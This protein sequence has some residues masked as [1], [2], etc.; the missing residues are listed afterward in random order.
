[1]ARENGPIP[2]MDTNSAK[3]YA[4]PKALLSWPGAWILFCVLCNV[5]GWT[6]SALNALRPAGYVVAFGIGLALLTIWQQRTGSPLFPRL[7]L[8]TL[9]AGF[10]K[11]LKTAFLAL[12][13]LTILGGILY[14]P[15][16]YDGLAYRVPR[17]L[18]WISEGRWHWIPTIFNRLN[19]RSCGIEWVS[20]PLVLFTHTDR[21]L[22]LINVI[23][24][25]LLP[26]LVYSTFV[27]LGVKQRVAWF[28]MWLVPTGYCYLLQAG[29]IGNDLFGSVFPLAALHFALRA[30]RRQSFVDAGLA[31]LAA[32]LATSSKAS[33]LPLV[34]PV[35]V[36]LVPCRGLLQ[37]KFVWLPLLACLSL[38]ASMVPTAWL[39]LRHC[40][41]WSGARAED[42]GG[43]NGNPLIRLP[44]NILVLGLQN[45]APPIFPFAGPWNLIA[46]RMIPSRFKE[47]LSRNY[48]EPGGYNYA[49]TELQWE[50]NAGFGCGLS[51]LLLAGGL[52]GCRSAK[53]RDEHRIKLMSPPH[54]SGLR[55]RSASNNL[56]WLAIAIACL[57]YLSAWC[58]SQVGRLAAPYYPFLAGGVLLLPGHSRVI[59]LACWKWLV[60][61]T[62]TL[63]LL[64]LVI[65][66]TRPLWPAITILSKLDKGE[67][68]VKLARETY[69]VNR[70]RP[71]ALAPLLLQIP[72]NQPVI[73]LLAFDEIETSLW[74]PFGHQR[75][76]HVTPW[77]TAVSLR[78]QGISQILIK[79]HSFEG[80]FHLPFSQ[81][82]SNVDG[83]LIKTMPLVS[84]G[85]IGIE[86]WQ[87]VQLNPLSSKLKQFK[88]ELNRVYSPAND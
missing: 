58:L 73:G 78:N 7:R 66:P 59:R 77:D 86:Y 80:Y 64:A 68:L 12:T 84:K 44:N 20:A 4:E 39:N 75:I 27:Q 61:A 21:W 47:V 26:G 10:C 15:S 63:S 13:C 70:Q 23:S 18:H 11:P 6:L 22:F 46:A 25:L 28:W 82:L 52:A 50:V 33:N 54:P 85:A 17:V 72:T 37:R 48:G 71:T 1:M 87:I 40:A 62:L 34:L 16:N 8:D 88:P 30:A 55:F 36:A 29:G 51:L 83:S 9:Y 81:W 56:V 60:G 69:E 79:T 41:D 45:L 35:L 65:M 3:A 74:R 5:T 24:F 49:L 32:A 43:L 14:S 67:K 57:T 19:T 38:L 42:V 31:I 53:I 2:I 76:V